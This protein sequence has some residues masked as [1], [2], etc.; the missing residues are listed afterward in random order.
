MNNLEKLDG[1][2]S[3]LPHL[4]FVSFNCFVDMPTSWSFPLLRTRLTQNSGKADIN[5]VAR[6][7]KPLI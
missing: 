4:K 7:K 6:T 5:M 2:L 3:Q 1:K